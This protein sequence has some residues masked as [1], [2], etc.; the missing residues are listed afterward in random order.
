MGFDVW[1]RS[2]LF[3]PTTFLFEYAEQALWGLEKCV[4]FSEGPLTASQSL[5][6][7]WLRSLLIV[8]QHA[9]LWMAGVTAV[10][11]CDS[12]CN[13]TLNTGIL[14][15]TGMARS[16]FGLIALRWG[17][18]GDAVLQAGAG[19]LGLSCRLHRAFL[20]SSCTG[21]GTAPSW[22]ALWRPSTSGVGEDVNTSS[23]LSRASRLEMTC[24]LDRPPQ[25]AFTQAYS[26]T[27]TSLL[28]P[29]RKQIMAPVSLAG[30]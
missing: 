19:G 12:R 29:R 2:S 3:P 14:M 8:G 1:V 4:S 23:V 7:A 18:C 27:M 6:V 11:G 10:L 20:S 24:R 21:F 28:P 26:P 15:V 13:G 16:C 17:N 30:R 9:R 25:P 22:V 5:G